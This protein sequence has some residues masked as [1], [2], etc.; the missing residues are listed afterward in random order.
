MEKGTDRWG[1][2]KLYMIIIFKVGKYII[3]P[4]VPKVPYYIQGYK[5]PI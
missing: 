5:L 2:L 4:H 1:T 3:I